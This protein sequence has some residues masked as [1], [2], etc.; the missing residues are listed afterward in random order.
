MAG[1]AFGG[2]IFYGHAAQGFNE[3]PNHPG[4]I[5]WYQALRANQ[6]FQMLDGKQRKI[7]LLG[8]PRSE[9]GTDT[10]KLSGRTD[11]PG[12][13]VGALSRDQKEHV[14]QVM[15]DVLA[16]FRKADAAEAMNLIKANGFDNLHLSFYKNLDIGNDGVWDVR[17]KSK[18]RPCSGISAARRMSTLGSMCA[19]SQPKAAVV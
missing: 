19:G 14:R 5:Y 17:G 2:P 15:A 10:V 3:K 7:A 11:L 12:I 1:T 6:V 9:Q 13:P 16:P 8:D 4:N 18:G